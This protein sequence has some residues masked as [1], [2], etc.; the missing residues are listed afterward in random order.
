MFSPVLE[1]GDAMKH[2]STFEEDDPHRQRVIL[3]LVRIVQM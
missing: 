1:N 2:L 3:R